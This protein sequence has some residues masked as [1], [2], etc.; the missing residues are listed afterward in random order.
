M[1]DG[2]TEPFVGVAVGVRDGGSVG[3]RDDHAVVG[4]RRRKS[5]QPAD[6]AGARDRTA[7]LV[8]QR[9]HLAGRDVAEAEYLSVCYVGAVATPAIKQPRALAGDVVEE[10]AGGAERR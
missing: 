1:V 4:V 7:G 3:Q 2:C 6:L 9:R 5:R 10:A 8:A